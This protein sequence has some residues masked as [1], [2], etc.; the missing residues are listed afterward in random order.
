M[1]GSGCSRPPTITERFQNVFKNGERKK[2]VLAWKTRFRVNHFTSYIWSWDWSPFVAAADPPPPNWC[3]LLVGAPW[4]CPWWCPWWTES[5]GVVRRS[6]AAP[7]LLAVMGRSVRPPPPPPPPTYE[8]RRSPFLDSE[9]GARNVLVVMFVFFSLQSLFPAGVQQGRDKWATCPGPR[10][11]RAPR[12]YIFW[13]N[14]LFGGVKTLFFSHARHWPF[15]LIY[16]LPRFPRNLA[17]A[18][19]YRVLRFSCTILPQEIGDRPLDGT[20]FNNQ[21]FMRRC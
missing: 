2:N 14:N 8:T 19:E 7:V 11:F 3:P 15:L 13:W 9:S 16:D 21:I 1:F 18:P 17:P 12:E 10:A 5:V 4:W 6:P 20:L